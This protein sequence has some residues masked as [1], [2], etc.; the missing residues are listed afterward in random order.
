V[1]Q[2]EHDAPTAIERG[3]D[4]GPIS[5]GQV[6]VPGGLRGVHRRQPEGLAPIPQVR[7]HRIDDELIG[8]LAGRRTNHAGQVG[9]KLRG[10]AVAPPHDGT[11]LVEK[12][13]GQGV[14]REPQR[15]PPRCI[16]RVGN[17]LGNADSKVSTGHD[18]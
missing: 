14:G 16:S 4:A 9:A 12:T 15:R 18:G 11:G 6:E 7:G 10:P 8:D 1:R 3:V 2:R 5:C 13:A 17:T